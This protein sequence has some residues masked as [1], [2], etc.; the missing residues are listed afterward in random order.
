[1][2]AIKTAIRGKHVIAVVFTVNEEAANMMLS[3]NNF[4]GI[5]PLAESQLIDNLRKEYHP[6]VRGKAVPF[7]WKKYASMEWETAALKEA[8]M[9][10]PAFA[11]K[12]QSEKAALKDNIDQYL[13]GLTPSS[14]RIAVNPF[15][16]LRHLFDKSPTLKTQTMS[17]KDG[18]DNTGWGCGACVCF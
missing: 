12:S 17:P 2:I 8:T 4:Q 9:A 18:D 16:I 1:L 13:D 15:S 6:I 11:N 5:Q 7:D 3:Y 14:D 10:D